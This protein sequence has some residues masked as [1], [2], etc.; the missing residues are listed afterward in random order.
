MAAYMPHGRAV[1][2]VIFEMYHSEDTHQLSLIRLLKHLKSKGIQKDDP[3]IMGLIKNFRDEGRSVSLDTPDP[4]LNQIDDVL[5]SKDSFGRCVSENAVINK[6]FKNQLIIPDWTSFTNQ[7]S[8]IYH[9]LLDETSGETAKYIP[10]LARVNPDKFAISVCTIDGQRQTWGDAE[11]LFCLQSVSKAFTYAIAIDELGDQFVHKYIGTER[12]IVCASLIKTTEA[13]S[14][15]FDF[16]M[17][18]IREFAGNGFL[19]FNNSVFLSER[20]TADRNY[21]LSYYMREHNCFPEGSKHRENLDLYFQLCSM[22]TNVDSLAVMGATLANGGVCPMTDKRVVCNTAVRDTLSLMLSCGSYD[23]SAQ[24]AFRVGLPAKSGVSGNFIIVIPNVASIAIYSPRLDSY[25]NSVRGVKF[26][27]KLV[28]IFNFH[29]YDSLIYNESNK[30]D[31]RL[32][33][34][35]VEML[36]ISNL[37]YAIRS[38]DIDFVR[39]YTLAG[40]FLEDS[41]YDNRTCLHVAASTGQTE[42]L[43][44]I[45]RHWKCSP[46]PR[47]IFD[48]TP[49]Q[50]AQKFNHISCVKVLEEAL[51]KFNSRRTSIANDLP[52]EISTIKKSVSNGH[53]TSP[54]LQKMNGPM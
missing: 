19:S 7:I 11:S 9:D 45:L 3:R 25:G 28:E 2:D 39:K 34:I 12:A 48:Q 21:A 53:A 15:R 46:E 42:I 8:K 35:D 50:N 54:E 14:E 1:S 20:E 4:Q 23:F 5:V 47:D 40:I 44:Y 17:K 32:K 27:E 24:F 33:N 29:H 52:P 10:Q 6:V 36:N 43:E 18:R 31:P 22:E 30:I 37:L 16:V 41:D 13:L 38:G 26:C 51:T 49:L